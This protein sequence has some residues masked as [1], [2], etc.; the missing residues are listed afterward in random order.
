MVRKL[1]HCE[2]IVKCLCVA[3]KKCSKS[4]HK[5]KYFNGE[6][7]CS[8]L[9]ARVDID[10]KRDTEYRVCWDLSKQVEEYCDEKESDSTTTTAA[11]TPPLSLK[12]VRISVGDDPIVDRNVEEVAPPFKKTRRRTKAELVSDCICR[13]VSKYRQKY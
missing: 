3:H 5:P 8:V 10:L 11:L 6:L 9:G 7:L 1:F 13:N 12:R 4:R 2:S